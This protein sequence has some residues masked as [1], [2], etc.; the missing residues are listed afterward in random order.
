[1][2]EK[3]GSDIKR[4]WISMTSY[5]I[6]FESMEIWTIIQNPESFYVGSDSFQ[7]WFQKWN[8]SGLNSLNYENFELNSILGFNDEQNELNNSIKNAAHKLTGKLEKIKDQIKKEEDQIKKNKESMTTEHR[9]KKSMV[10]ISI[11][12]LIENV[13]GLY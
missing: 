12:F 4:L 2:S 11:T 8:G 1:M 10:R 9:I 5:T 13:R 6:D 7:Q 3:V